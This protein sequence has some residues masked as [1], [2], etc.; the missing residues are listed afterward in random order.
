MTVYSTAATSV[1]LIASL[2]ACSPSADGASPAAG[3]DRSASSAQTTALTKQTPTP[4]P[5]PPTVGPPT[6]LEV[7]SALKERLESEAFYMDVPLPQDSVVLHHFDLVQAVRAENPELPTYRVMGKATLVL[8]KDGMSISSGSTSINTRGMMGD[9]V[10]RSVMQKISAKSRLRDV[11]PGATVEHAVMAVLQRNADGIWSPVMVE[12]EFSRTAGTVK[13]LYVEDP[14]PTG[15]AVK[16]S[17]LAAGKVIKFDIADAAEA[18]GNAA[19]AAAEAA[20]A[21]MAHSDE[22]VH[23]AASDAGSIQPAAA[24]HTDDNTRRYTHLATINDPDGYTNVRSGQSSSSSVVAKVTDGEDF[25]VTP[26]AGAWWPV[27]TKSGVEGFIHP[28]R[29]RLGDTLK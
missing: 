23:M 13:S 10:K 2:S 19:L 12:H 18:S 20:L 29:V 22:L 9:E 28:S 7:R 25:E 27:R 17:Q 3:D 26:Q 21:S 24:S 1:L 6:A 5:V 16:A 4:E 15:Q 11:F 8:T 14:S